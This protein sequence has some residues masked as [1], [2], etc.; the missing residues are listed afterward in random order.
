MLVNA[1]IP[2]K[3]ISEKEF[4]KFRSDWLIRNSDFELLEEYL[5]QNQAF[6]I[7]PKLTKHLVNFYLA[8]ANIEKSC[9]IFSKNQEVLKDNYLS[10]FNIYCLIVKNK[11]EE[12]QI[13][14]DLKKETGFKDEYFEKKIAFL[15]GLENKVDEKVSEKSILDF[16]LAHVTNPNFIFE[17]ND[18][19]KK[20]YGSI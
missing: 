13:I 19:T 10:K 4:I 5:I 8:E 11:N 20:L 2:T 1:Y 17:P 3:N 6:N 12:A 14:L 16:H 15:I 7:Y 18:K 9:E